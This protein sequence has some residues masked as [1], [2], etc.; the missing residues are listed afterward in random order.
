MS[1]VPFGEPGSSAQL[2]SARRRG[3]ATARRRSPP[4]SSSGTGRRRR[5]VRAALRSRRRR[6]CAASRRADPPRPRRRPRRPAATSPSC[7]ARDQTNFPTN[8]ERGGLGSPGSISRWRSTLRTPST[9]S[10]VAA[11]SSCPQPPA[12]AITPGMPGQRGGTRR[13]AAEPALVELL[14]NDVR[15]AERERDRV[16]ALLVRRR[17]VDRERLERLDHVAAVQV[18][19]DIGRLDHLL[20]DR[21]RKHDRCRCRRVSRGSCGSGSCRPRARRT[22]TAAGTTPC[23]RSAPR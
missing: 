1:L 22:A 21:G 17:V 8:R 9:S 20:E 11:S 5:A 23:S 10:D 3:R 15:Q 7:D 18:E 4:G 14:A 19:Q 13:H 12:S 6:A 2:S 16:R